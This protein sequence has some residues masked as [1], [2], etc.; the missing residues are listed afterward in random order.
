MGA[1]HKDCHNPHCPLSNP[2]GHC[3]TKKGYW[4]IWTRGPDKG[5][6]LH[7]WV[8]EKLTGEKPGPDKE[9]HH[10]DFD[11]LYCCPYNL[12]VMDYGLHQALDNSSRLGMQKGIKGFQRRPGA[13]DEIDK[14]V[15]EMILAD[16][17]GRGRQWSVLKALDRMN[18]AQCQ[19]GLF[20]QE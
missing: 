14:L 2:P 8:I 7:R 16:W 19:Q 4:R 10:I 5:K 15:V 11:P 20:G 3:L 13:N 9:I 12:A 1:R 17:Q 18:P 6:Y